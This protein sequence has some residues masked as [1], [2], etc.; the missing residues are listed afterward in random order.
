[1]MLLAAALITFHFSLL[2]ATAENYP[3]RSDY[4]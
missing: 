2:T 3:Y 4:L 1:M